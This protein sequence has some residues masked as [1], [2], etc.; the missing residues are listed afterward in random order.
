MIRD[1]HIE[2]FWYLASPYSHA[3]SKVRNQREE[4][5]SEVGAQ[6]TIRGLILFCPITQSHRLTAM[7]NPTRVPSHEGWM[8]IDYA[9]LNRA[10]G[11]IV[12]KLNGWQESKG[13]TEEIEFAK[14]H[15]MP[16][17]YLEMHP[18]DKQ[19][20]QCVTDVGS[21]FRKQVEKNMAKIPLSRTNPHVVSRDVGASSVISRG[22][23]AHA[24]KL[25]K[26]MTRNF[27]W[28]SLGN[29]IGRT[30]HLLCMSLEPYSEVNVSLALSGLA[31]TLKVTPEDLN[32]VF[33]SGA[34]KHGIGGHRTL[35]T[36]ESIPMLVDSMGRHILKGVDN[37]DDESGLPHRFHVIANVAMI[38]Q[39]LN[40]R[41]ISEPQP[42]R[43]V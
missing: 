31:N 7:L 17:I 4:A 27:P 21:A 29:T 36:R 6:L 16:I 14:K 35:Y 43:G 9:F 19:L 10:Q 11:L 13:V 20:D 8:R 2:G 40:R 34:K 30:M 23:R 39:V 22:G 33:I 3:N 37:L 5:V 24:E 12:Y 26:P 41:T 32:K 38:Q 28:L 42:L 1:E 15:N 25:N 18:S